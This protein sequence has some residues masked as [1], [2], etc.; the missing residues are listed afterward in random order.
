MEFDRRGFP[1][2]VSEPSLLL[3]AEDQFI[4]KKVFAMRVHGDSMQTSEGRNSF[5]HG[6]IVI[7]DDRKVR[8]GSFVFLR[9]RDGIAF[10]QIFFKDNGRVRLLPL[11][12]TY[13]EEHLPAANILNMRR[14][15][16]HLRYLT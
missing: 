10:R 8:S 15:A 7:L 14:V 2:G 5:A 11:N 1:M 6:D 12:R 4:G 3:P 9:T 16:A 13:P